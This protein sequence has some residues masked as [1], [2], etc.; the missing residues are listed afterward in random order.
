MNEQTIYDDFLSVRN[1]VKTCFLQGLIDEQEFDK[2]YKAT[3]EKYAK[4]LVD[5]G[6]LDFV[7]AEISLL[8]YEKN[9]NKAMEEN[10]YQGR[11]L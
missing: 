10:M 5:D 7:N 4:E 9:D 3:L 6:W 8:E 1:F 2:K 11:S